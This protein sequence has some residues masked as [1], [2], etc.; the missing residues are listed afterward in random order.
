[1]LLDIILFKACRTMCTLSKLIK[2]NVKHQT[3]QLLYCKLKVKYKYILKVKT[4]TCLILYR[5]P[6]LQLGN[7]AWHRFKCTRIYIYTC[8]ISIGDYK[9]STQCRFGKLHVVNVTNLEKAAISF[10]EHDAVRSSAFK[11]YHGR[12]YFQFLVALAVIE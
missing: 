9:S 6:P 5:M 3:T 1:M 7:T 2:A 11:H 8:L 12:C 4:L 10:E